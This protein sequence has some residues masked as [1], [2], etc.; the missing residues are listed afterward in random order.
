VLVQLGRH[1]V[2]SLEDLAALLADAP[3][4]ALADVIILRDGRLGRARMK[5]RG[6]I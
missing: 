6:A 1:P 4:G 3:H 2:E 5:L